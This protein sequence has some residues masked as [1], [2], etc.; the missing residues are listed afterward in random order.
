MGLLEFI[1]GKS[2][3]KDDS[4]SKQAYYLNDDDAKSFGNIDYMRTVKTVRRTFAKKKGQEHM[5]SIRQISAMQRADA[6]NN[7]NSFGATPSASASTSA[8]SNNATGNSSVPSAQRPRRK[9]SSDMDMFRNMA[10]DMRK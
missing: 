3:P 8:S 9:A 1:F 7:G 5:E 4:Q 2:A 10:K 6:A